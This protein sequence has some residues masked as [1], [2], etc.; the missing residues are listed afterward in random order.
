MGESLHEGL[1]AKTETP[2]MIAAIKLLAMTGARVSEIL[3]ARWEWIDWERKVLSLPDSKTGERQIY[4][5][6][7]A[8]G[9]LKDLESLQP[10]SKSPFVIQGR[11][12]DRPL[13]NISKAWLRIRERANLDDVRIHDLRHTAASIGVGQGMGLPI[14]GRLLGH[15]HASTTQRYAHVDID[16]A[17]AAANQIGDVVSNALS[18]G[19]KIQRA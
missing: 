9:V 1:E 13:I 10:S 14:V 2:H 3:S 19:S 11:N 6:N 5:S 16:P 4:L 15:T 8:L 18:N 7:A 17:L 12:S